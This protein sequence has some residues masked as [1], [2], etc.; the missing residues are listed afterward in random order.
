MGWLPA[1]IPRV[2]RP[3]ELAADPLAFLARARAEHGDL[4]VLREEGPL[5]SRAPDCRG[6]VAVFGAERQRIVLGDLDCFGM[7]ISA[8]R[9]LG[10]P[11]PLI[12]LNR[13]L[14]SMTGEPHAAQRRLLGGILGAGIDAYDGD[15]RATLGEVTRG[16]RAGATFGLLGAMRELATAVSSQLLFG[17]AGE[18]RDRLVW[19]LRS[20]FHLRR[21]VSSPVAVA[22]DG[23]L[24]A[25]VAL[26]LA[27]D[28]ALRAHVRRCRGG[29]ADA[30]RGLIADLATARTET[31]ALLAEDD[32]VA[33]A[34]VLFISGTEPIAVSLTWILLLLDRRPALR[35]RLR[36]ELAGVGEAGGRTLLDD[37]IAEVLRLVPPNA[38]MVRVTKREAALFDA[39]LPERCEIVVCPFVAHRDPARFPEPGRFLPARWRTIKP[40]PFEYMPFGAGGHACIGK[41]LARHLLDRALSHILSHY[42]LTLAHDQEIDWRVHIMLMPSVDPVI[43]VRDPEDPRER[44]GVL[45]GPVA[46]LFGGEDP[47]A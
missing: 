32:V 34:N 8:A 20:Y 24:E 14:H 45:T 5:F 30:P 4:V 11:P 23:V 3:D 39:V 38:L 10:L 40:S 22:G 42:A 36:A 43:A 7:P 29:G 44:D 41:A 35:R 17:A 15:L 33:H 46:E 12:Q 31:G 16:W 2:A 25:L 27:L 28:E 18:T 21:E 26:G 13:G 1:A 19:L 9:Q 6:V 37:T 47:D